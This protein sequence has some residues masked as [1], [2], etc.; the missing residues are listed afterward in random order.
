[1][2]AVKLIRRVLALGSALVMTGALSVVAASQ[3]AAA[4]AIVLQATVDCLNVNYYGNTSDWYPSSL[5]VPT[6]PPYTYTPV[7]NGSLLA[8]PATHA[9]Q[10]AQTL[11]GGAT[12]VGIAAV[13]SSGHQ[14]GDYGW[15]SGVTNIPSG[16]STV[17]ANWGCST[18][19]VYPGPWTTTCSLQSVSFS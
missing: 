19:P 8:I 11:P 2:F 15:A 10:F 9:F 4:A 12:S 16:T 3:P 13:C 18:G 5:Q 14:Y 7:P 6:S 1:M 17:T